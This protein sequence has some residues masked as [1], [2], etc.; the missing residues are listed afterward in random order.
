[1]FKNYFKTAWRSLLKNKFYSLLNIAGLAAGLTVGTIILLW[2]QDELGYD[3]F[4]KN[5]KQIYR[6]ENQVGTGSS[7]QIWTVTNA[8]IGPNAMEQLPEISDMART[9]FN[10]FFTNYSYGDKVFVE[11]NTMFTDPGF[12]SIFDFP[13]IKGDPRN[14][15]LNA[16]S[17]VL[18]ES[19][20][21]RYF[22]TQEPIGKVIMGDHQAGFTVTGIIRDLPHNSS[23]NGDM[24]FPMTAFQ[25]DFARRHPGRSMN[26][27][28]HEYNFATYLLVRPGV[29]VKALAVK[30]RQVH[31]SHKADDTDI[32]Y[33]PL[34]LSKLHLY[35]A[36]GTD[37][38]IGAVRIFTLIA[39]LILAIACIN[40]VNLSTARSMLRVREVSVRK[41]LGALRVQLFMQFVMETAILFSVAI[42]IS[43]VAVHLCLPLFNQL[44][45]KTLNIDFADYHIWLVTGAV[46]IGTLLVASIYP[47]LLLSSFEP[48][49]ALKGKLVAGM[50]N[51][52]FRKV[53][54]VTQFVV[55]IV[56]IAG[57]II[58]AQQLR[59]IHNKNLGYDKS[60][61]FAFTLR[62]NEAHY[63]AIRNQLA[64]TP[65]V[66]DVTRAGENLVNVGQYSGNSD[67][68]GK[69]PNQSLMVR[70]ISIDYDFVPFFK[71]NLLQGHNF[72][73]TPA[74]SAYYILNETAVKL[75]GIKHPLGKRF[76]LHGKEGTIIGVVK[77]FHLTT[78]RQKI[79]PAVLYSQPASNDHIYVRINGHD[80]PQAIAAA[81][82]IWEQYSPG[83]PFSYTFLD[84]AFEN[85]Y[86]AELRTGNLFNTFAGIAIFISC[87]GLLGLTA[88]T[89]QVR[90]QEIG[91]RK[92]L[93]ASVGGIV[94]LLA[95]QF[96][97]LVLIALVIAI[98]LS[99]YAM[100]QWLNSFAYS[101]PI[102][103]TVFLMAGAAAIGIAIGTVSYQSVKAALVNPVKSLR[104]E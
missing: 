82:R 65:G 25:Q 58:I 66:T 71:M 99:W 40:Y 102:R 43:A 32:Q 27:D 74:D 56:L 46:A 45:G 33:L 85:L 81:R 88:Y 57:T 19:T 12:F 97:R 98:P 38:G 96:V 89:A 80:A 95:G 39:L 79:E 87:L 84:A 86:S 35:K 77:D 37:N 9:T 16:A 60:F 62:N 55:S 83:V 47:A 69:D 2:V 49:K 53:L 50:N 61:V 22:G 3:R 34:A 68:D 91:V 15:F 73:G 94:T 104:S 23:L 8:G 41:V 21:R 29:D 10:Y 72:F 52:V 26:N 51:A 64:N 42:A 13:L 92:V 78:L 20:A 76:R 31:L 67:W 17:V 1:M 30:L 24:F 63:A 6:L 90:R 28:Y 93:G 5:V 59:Y 101:I 7:Q 14:P 70:P 18:T 75:T 100:Q 44:S 11:N 103:W 4:H 36:D 54:V 48:V